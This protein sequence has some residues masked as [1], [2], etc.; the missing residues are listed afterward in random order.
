[1][2]VLLINGSSN[3]KGCTYTALK[4]VADSLN[5]EDIETE[6]IQLG[7]GAYRDCIGCQACNKLDNQCVFKDDMVNEIIEKAKS[8]DGFVF[9][10]PVYYAHPSGR[11]L[12]VL[13]RA[14][15]AASDVFKFKP[16]AAVVSARRAG[17]TASVDILNKYFT[18]NNM[19]VVSSSYWNMVHG[20]TPEDVKQDIE[21]LQIMRQIGKNMAWI[22]KN[23]QK[24][25]VAYQDE[26]KIYTNFI[27]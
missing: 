24:G 9:G 10:S 16:G 25:N 23:I 15:Y 27:A 14:F 3:A 6:I 8:A 22:L 20:N 4:E 12:S 19:P 18:I 7:K 2:K 11:I 17:T 13:D 21:G 1:M 5:K 26:E